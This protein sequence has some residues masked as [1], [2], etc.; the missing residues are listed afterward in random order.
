ME[1]ANDRGVVMDLLAKAAETSSH[2][3]IQLNWTAPSGV[4]HHDFILVTH[5]PASVVSRIVKECVMVHL[6]DGG[7]LIPLKR[8]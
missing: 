7:L 2:V 8:A 1:I 4:V 6:V 3:K 5:A